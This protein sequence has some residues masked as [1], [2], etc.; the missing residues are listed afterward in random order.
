MILWMEKSFTRIIWEKREL[1]SMALDHHRH[2][3]TAVDFNKRAMLT[4][5]LNTQHWH[6][7]FT[8]VIRNRKNITSQRSLDKNSNFRCQA[9][10]VHTGRLGRWSIKIVFL[11]E[12]VISYEWQ[13]IYRINF[14]IRLCKV[15]GE[16]ELGLI[17]TTWSLLHQ[18]TQKKRLT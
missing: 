15:L 1:F 11:F 14:F 10:V 7:Q 18:Q 16:I 17:P 2:D 8:C 4:L 13:N 6:K 9:A 12:F 5:K 3:A